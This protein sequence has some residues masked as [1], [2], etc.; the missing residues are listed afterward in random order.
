MGKEIGQLLHLLYPGIQ[1][2]AVKGLHQ[3]EAIKAILEL[4]PSNHIMVVLISLEYLRVVL[5]LLILLEM[6][7]R[8]RDQ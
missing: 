3:L 8:R 2:V 5:S 6:F 7:I 4:E 1:Q